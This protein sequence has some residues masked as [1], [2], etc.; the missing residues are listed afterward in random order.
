MTVVNISP[1][2]QNSWV[3][4]GRRHIWYFLGTC[5]CIVVFG[6]F[7]RPVCDKSFGFFLNLSQWNKICR[8]PFIVFMHEQ[9]CT[10]GLF[11]QE[12]LFHL[13]YI[14]CYLTGI[15][16]QEKYLSSMHPVLKEEP[17]QCWLPFF[18]YHGCTNVCQPSRSCV[19][20]VPVGFY[21]NNVSLS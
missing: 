4:C 2:D 12:L 16:C 6:H 11:S 8:I 20:I 10:T 14:L 13:H 3:G 5:C 21:D 17:V 19:C 9:R 7:F 15:W 18:S 1:V